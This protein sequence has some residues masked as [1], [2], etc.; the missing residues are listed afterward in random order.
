MA[1]DEINPSWRAG[2][3]FNFCLCGLCLWREFYG[4]DQWKWERCFLPYSK[5]PTYKPLSFELSEMRRCMWLQQGTGT[6]AIGVRQRAFRLLLPAVLQLCHLPPP[7]PPP[8]SNCSCLFTGCRPLCA[9]CCTV[10]LYF[11]KH[12]KCFTFGLLFNVL[13]VWKEL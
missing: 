2:S 8:A 9:S 5:L 7:L 6:C 3:D 1:C 12:E 4:D 13:F 11:L 10:L